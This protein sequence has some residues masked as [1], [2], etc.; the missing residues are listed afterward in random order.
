MSTATPQYETLSGFSPP[1]T[2]GPYRA[3]DYW[4]L[5]EGEPVE[6]IQGHLVVSP[7]P[8]FVHQA[9][10]ALLTEFILGAARKGGGKGCAAHMDVELSDHSIP[11][12][13][14][15]YIAK[16]RRHIVKRHVIG[17]P[18][19]VI[20]ILSDNPRR[21]RVDKM[22]IYAEFGVA[23]YWIV[24]PK[25]R[26]FDFL[27]NRDGRFEVQPQHDNRYQSPRLAELSIH[28]VAFWA[29]VERMTSDSE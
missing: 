9:I 29:E 3:A 14:L 23:E 28:L 17:P 12:P 18:D 19:L 1:S 7:S 13:D 10:S 25:Q 8:N 5:P 26:L 24:D 16:E 2:L 22:N 15:L 6:L 27:I 21:D 20:E 4:K 11:Q